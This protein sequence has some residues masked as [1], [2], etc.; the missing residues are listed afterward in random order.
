MILQNTLICVC[1]QAAP[2]VRARA[3]GL[4]GGAHAGAGAARPAAAAGPAGAGPAH[5]FG[6][7]R[8]GAC[9]AQLRLV[10]L[11]GCIK[12]QQ[13]PFHAAPVPT[14]QFPH[15]KVRHGSLGCN[16]SISCRRQPRRCSDGST[17]RRQ[18]RT[19]CCS[20]P[21]SGAPGAPW[22]CRRPPPALPCQQVATAFVQAA[23]MH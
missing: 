19:T 4:P 10:L 2:V 8:P 6:P 1:G 12:H 5:H 15:R 7:R 18:W 13:G 20:T 17:A 23:A 11:R 22:C 16:R 21:C 14:H 9:V 3:A